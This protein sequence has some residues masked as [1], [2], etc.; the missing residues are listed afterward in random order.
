MLCSFQSRPTL[1]PC[2][3]Y[4]E[5]VG[6]LSCHRIC[7]IIM[8]SSRSNCEKG[9]TTDYVS[10]I[11]KGLEDQMDI[12]GYRRHV[13]FTIASWVLVVLSLGAVKLIFYWWPHI[14]LYCTNRQCSV[15][16]AEKLLIVE[17]SKNSSPGYHV[18]T[19]K[20]LVDGIFI[21][22]TSKRD[23][24]SCGEGLTTVEM[25]ELK[26]QRYIWDNKTE[27]FVRLSGL[28]KVSAEYLHKLIGLSASERKIRSLLYGKNEI[29]VPLQGV[30][31]LL[32]SEVLNPFYIFQI[33]SFCLWF[34]YEYVSYAVTIITMSA[35][36]IILTVIQTR[37][38]QKKLHSTICSKDYVSVIQ[39]NNS[40]E[41]EL[42]TV[43][44]DRLVPGD[45]IVIPSHGCTMF[46]DA[47]LL[48]GSCIVN[49]S[50]LT[51]ESVP[52]TK[53]PLPNSP[54]VVYDSND[55]GKHTLY[56]GTRVIKTRPT[57]KMEIYAVVIQ[58][59]FST[60][61]GGLV[62]SI[63][64]PAHLTF[65]FEE[66]SYKF[67]Q[68]MSVFACFGFLYTVITKAFRGV[69]TATIV[70]EAL[71]LVTIV[72]PPS[73]PAA[74]AVG[75][76][77]AQSRLKDQNIFCVSPRM[78]N[79]AGCID[80]VCFDKTGTL[81]EDKPELW[82]VVPVGQD[83]FD[84][85]IQNV[86]LLRQKHLLQAM[87]TCHSLSIIDDQL[88]GDPLDIKMFEWTSW[89]LEES[90][91]KNERSTHMVVLPSTSFP[92]E[93]LQEIEIVHQLPFSSS[94]QRMTVVTRLKGKENEKD[95]SCLT[96]YS[97]G[98]PEVIRNICNHLSIPEDFE[99]KL[100]EY[101]AKGCRVL[102]I[103][104]KNDYLSVDQLVREEIEKDFTFL[105]LIVFENRLKPG[106]VG[107]I[108]TLQAANIH[109]VMVTGD[110]QLTAVS[111]ARECGI[112]AANE[113][114]FLV[115]VIPPRDDKQAQLHYK[116]CREGL[117]SHIMQTPPF[118]DEIEFELASNK[119]HVETESEITKGQRK[120]HD[121]ILSKPDVIFALTGPTWD[122]IHTYCPDQVPAIV[123]RCT[124]FARMTPD[125]KQQLVLCLQSF[126][127]YVGM[128]G[129]GANDCGAL[130]TAH[131]GIS[132]SEAESSVASPFTSRKSTVDCV[133]K[134]IQEGRAAL[135][136]SF[137]IFKFMAGYSIAQFVSVMIL[138]SVDSNLTDIQYLFVD[139]FII[140]VF[141]FLLGRTE[142]NYGPLSPRAP[143][144]SLLSPVTV[145]S[146][147]GQVVIVVVFQI[148]CYFSL[149][150][151]D[152]F[153]PYSST[154]SKSPGCFEN[155]ALFSISSM[156]YIILAVVFC[157]GAPYRMPLSKNWSFW[158]VS[159][160]TTFFISYLILCPN[161]WLQEQFELVVPMDVNFRIFCIVLSLINF[162]CAGIYEFYVCDVLLSSKS[163][164]TEG[165]KKEKDV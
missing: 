113:A 159:V 142:A 15:R 66:D 52:V 97:K 163:R 56:C 79:V 110:N 3:D 55:H 78:I 129:D 43:S 81:T 60:M 98:A 152:W 145:S 35:V 151:R 131:T 12:Y 72:V 9:I 122:S 49:E 63:L 153:D 90:A 123:K 13:W 62:R 34:V 19:V 91:P 150:Q 61:K 114:V 1:I 7:T 164:S 59:G 86:N 92:K 101:T 8:E 89:V 138:Y 139:L 4:Q 14:Q 115:T 17:H 25:F 39:T 146:L 102:G 143:E 154:K 141:A 2:F 42:S 75:C 16:T 100:E 88:C 84:F 47:V 54:S 57:S 37:D 127:Y 53:I 24:S 161:Q 130:K 149:L 155:Y 76:I 87:S 117:V 40:K 96:I 83:G 82:G 67:I 157:K 27:C 29:T 108:K 148:I 120:I 65:K 5:K 118:E 133:V 116:L 106:T 158:M 33:F 45:V 46:C 73:L 128:C 132:L 136:T 22:K 126:G 99:K 6:S 41:A 74:M 44:T 134:L 20:T 26:K 162:A 125:Q 58:T 68:L 28:E 105:G 85:P 165:V 23:F 69:P 112:V 135:V 64:Y 137:S 30:V 77:S 70:L 103:A 50:I 121:E 160:C 36:G 144:M 11:N 31:E 140:S 80:C 109:T 124:V 48:S 147:V 71:D 18:E 107:V 119:K 38:N 94:L 111:V 51:G 93:E 156:Q 21:E 10:F 95:D 104:Y 32:V